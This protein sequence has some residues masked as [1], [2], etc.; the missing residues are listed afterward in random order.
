[1]ACYRD[2]FIFCLYSTV[3]RILHFSYFNLDYLTS[4]LTATRLARVYCNAI[5]RGAVPQIKSLGLP[6]MQFQIE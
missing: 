4:R 3:K 5:T 6:A 1:M 2:S